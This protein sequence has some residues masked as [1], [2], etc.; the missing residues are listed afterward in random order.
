MMHKTAKG[1]GFLLCLIL[2]ML[3]RFEFAIIGIVLLA[4]HFWLGLPM[5]LAWIAFGVWFVY[6]L[7]I[8][9]ILSLANH[10][11][12]LPPDERPNKNPYSASNKDFMTD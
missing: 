2:N 11:G 5:F 8:T 4:L 3:F 6:A 9:V 1:H 12:N 10:A 7:L